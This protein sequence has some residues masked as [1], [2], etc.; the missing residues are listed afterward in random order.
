MDILISCLVIDRLFFD[1]G[2]INRINDELKKCN[3]F[4]LFL[5]IICVPL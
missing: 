2:G 4:F 5:E 3:I 1:K